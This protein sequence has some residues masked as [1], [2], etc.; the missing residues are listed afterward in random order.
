MRRARRRGRH[1]R[2]VPD[3]DRTDLHYR[4]DERRERDRTHRREHSVAS[5]YSDA[6]Y[7]RRGSGVH[8]S[9]IGKQ[10]RAFETRRRRSARH[11][12]APRI[13]EH[14]C[15]ADYPAPLNAADGLASRNR[16]DLTAASWRILPS[17]DLSRCETKIQPPDRDSANSGLMLS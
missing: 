10:T 2:T 17:T 8:S 12:I 5:G 16:T 14:A 6:A 4:A 3:E 13:G 1:R 15:V 9:H 11:P 7:G